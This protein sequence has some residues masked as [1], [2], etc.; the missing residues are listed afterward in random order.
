[1]VCSCEG[2]V[3]DRPVAKAAE[4]EA[5]ASGRGCRGWHVKGAATAVGEATD[6]LRTRIRSLW[7]PVTVPMGGRWPGARSGER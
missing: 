7:P 5:V 4:R 1:M 6:S 2:A 3:R